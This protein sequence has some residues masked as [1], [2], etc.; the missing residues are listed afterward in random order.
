MATELLTW[1]KEIVW[2]DGLEIEEEGGR[3]EDGCSP[4]LASG[5][6]QKDFKSGSD[7]K[8]FKSG[9]DHKDF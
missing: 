4:D 8:D 3:G 6:D 7:Q 2:I 5:S 1:Q 9:S